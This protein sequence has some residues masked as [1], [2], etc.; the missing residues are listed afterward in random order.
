MVRIREVQALS[1]FEAR[2][3]FTD[4]TEKVVDL[5]AY[6]RGPIF[7]PLR[8][9]PVAFRQMRVDKELGTICWPNGADIDPDVLYLG[10]AP[11]WQDDSRPVS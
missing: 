9:D 8:A 4:G 6:L 2:L 10:V 5:D 11:A 1:G 3:T 7:E